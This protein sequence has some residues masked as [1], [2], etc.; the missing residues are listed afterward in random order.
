M[1]LHSLKIEGFKRIQSAKVLFGDATFLIGPNNAG[2]S[3]VLKAIEWLLSAKKTIPSPEYFSIV[4]EETGETKPVVDTITLEAEFRNLPIEANQWRGFKGRIFSYPVDDAS[5]SGLSVTYR[6]TFVLGKDVVI[7]F[8]SKEREI[9]P[10]FADFKTGQDLIDKGVP[11]AEVQ[12]MFPD[13]GTKIGSSK[14]ALEKLE[15]LDAIWDTK[16]TET[17]FQN[18][19][20]IPGVVLKMLPRFLLIPA[21]TSATEIE[22]TPS[23][24]LGKTL[25][26]LFEDVRG[27]SENY[28]QAQEY[29]NKLAQELNPEDSGSEFGKMITELNAV[30]ASVFPDSQLHATASLS[31]PKTALKPTFNVEMSSNVRTAVNHQGSGMIR[32]AAFG[33]LRFRQKWLSKREDDHVRSLIVCFEEP[34][35]YLHPSAANQMRDTIYELSGH[36]SQ[37]VATTHS[38]FIIDL[39]RKPKQIL[40]SLRLD[41]GGV[42]S[43]P[44]NVTDA[45]RALEDDSKAHVKMLLRVDD[46]VARVFFTKHVLIVEGDTEEVVIKETLKRL[47]KDRYLKI[48]S[49]FEIV[50]ARGKA[51]IIGLV[52]YLVAMGI[53]P[54]VVHDRDGGV[55]GA[56]I[57]NQPIADALAGVGKVV[58]MRESI[59]DEMG[60]AAPTSEKPFKAYQETQ[61]WGDE[62]NSMPASWKAKMVEIFGDYVES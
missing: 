61:Q 41:S 22:G 40:N 8:K 58:Q 39:S 13:L 23:G 6:K 12:D 37:I 46:Y 18:P 59:E 15:Q 17:W 9:K 4:D 7:E 1:K 11:T 51:S 30:L 50:K 16:E 56:E 60:Y 47:P 27:A 5:D 31:D 33:M 14:G 54:I 57:F 49:D 32:A 45:Y 3:T 36:E 24:V 52:K 20:G 21:D 62:W 25:N 42:T 34:E 19:G 55:A 48:V 53:A 26:E 38:P 35:I 44:F 2:K 29:L 43:S 10:E 28:A